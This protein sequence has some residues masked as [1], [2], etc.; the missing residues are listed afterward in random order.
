VCFGIW[1]LLE[2][3]GP[4]HDLIGLVFPQAA[5]YVDTYRTM[6]MIYDPNNVCL[7]RFEYDTLRMKKA[8]L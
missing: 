3:A 4:L 6:K 1:P 5:T 8:A 2:G 7:R